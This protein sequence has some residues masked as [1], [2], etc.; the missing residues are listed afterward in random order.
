M[1]RWPEVEKMQKALAAGFVPKAAVDAA[2]P[3]AKRW[4]N[5]AAAT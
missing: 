3:D 5:S 2:Q 1:S 4:E